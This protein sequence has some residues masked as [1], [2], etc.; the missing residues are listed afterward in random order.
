MPVQNTD[1]MVFGDS[2]I[3]SNCL[4]P[5]YASLRHLSPGSI[6]LFGRYGRS[7][8]RHSF[9]LD[10]C[11][12][13]DYRRSMTPIPLETPGRDLLTDAVLGPLFTEQIEGD[14]SVYF[15]RRRSS[16]AAS[17]F[18]F[19]PAR[20]ALDHP[21]LFAR[22]ELRPVGALRD[23]ISPGN[24]QGIKLTRD[25]SAIDRD[26][27]WAEVVGQVTDQGCALGY[28]AATPPLVDEDAAVSASGHSPQPL[29]SRSDRG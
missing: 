11:L 3:Y 20:L 8:G 7:D 28:A 14:L 1:P 17:T 12:V 18:S 9:S 22:P 6:V 19:F 26:A 4:Q 21:P 23:K 10:T 13:V 24:M 2:F 27:V 5:T 16:G 15:G 25:L 29:S